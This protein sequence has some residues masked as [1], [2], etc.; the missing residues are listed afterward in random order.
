M[1]IFLL[2]A[3][4]NI[5][6]ALLILALTVLVIVVTVGQ[7]RKVVYATLVDII[8]VRSLWNQ[9]INDTNN[10]QVLAE[11][12]QKELLLNYS[13]REKMLEAESATA[14]M[15]IRKERL[16]ILASLENNQNGTGGRL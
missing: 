12:K 13:H 2:S 14:L 6:L 9:S 10:N 11:I 3:L 1:T 15:P 5:S 4:I 8:N 7:V 16:G